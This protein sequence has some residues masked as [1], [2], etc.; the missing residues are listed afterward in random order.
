MK[1]PMT[2]MASAAAL[3]LALSPA[4]GLSEMA[5]WIAGALAVQLG[6]LLAP[7]R[8]I[9]TTRTRRK[10]ETG[11]WGWSRMR[12]ARSMQSLTKFRKS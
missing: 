2:T 10:I 4:A 8:R 3:A 1:F 12:L 6:S 7:C 9:L 5:Q 11:L